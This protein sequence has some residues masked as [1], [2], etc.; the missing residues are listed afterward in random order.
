LIVCSPIK[1]YNEIA[2]YLVCNIDLFLSIFPQ[3]GIL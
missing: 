2:N 3:H 1:M